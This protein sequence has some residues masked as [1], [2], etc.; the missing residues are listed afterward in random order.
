MSLHCLKSTSTS[1]GDVR[2]LNGRDYVV[3]PV[4]ALVEGVRHAGGSPHPELV[5]AEAFGRHV[6]TWNGRPI[7][8]DHPIDDNGVSVLA[9]SPG[10]LETCYL[11]TLLNAEVSDG[12]LKTEAWLDLSAIENSSSDKVVEMWERLV[13]GQTVEVSVGAIV[14]T[15]QKKGTYEGKKYSGVWDIVIP[16]HLAFLSGD[17]IGACSIDDGCG[18]YRTQSLGSLQLSEGIRMAVKG[19]RS[20][21]SLKKVRAAADEVETNCECGCGGSGRCAGADE[22]DTVEE[23]VGDPAEREVAPQ[24]LSDSVALA[25]AVHRVLF[26]MDT[27]DHDRRAL[28]SRALRKKFKDK[29]PYTIAYNDSMV[30][31]EVYEDDEYKLY[32]VA[33]TSGDDNSVSIDGEPEEVIVQSK[34][35]PVVDAGNKSM[36]GR[37]REDKSMAKVK[38]LETDED[39]AVVCASIDELMKKLDGTDVG[40]ALKAQ[41]SV[42]S[43]AKDKVVE[44]ILSS[45]GG[46]HFTKEVLSGMDFDVL[47]RMATAMEEAAAPPVKQ[48]TVAEMESPDELVEDDGAGETDLEDEEVV[49]EVLLSRKKKNSAG[50]AQRNYAGRPGASSSSARSANAVPAAPD[51]FDDFVKSGEAA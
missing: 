20:A 47:E 34:V 46:K 16:D 15:Q 30:L 24:R 26:S 50:T 41:L 42:A 32:Q 31:F 39:D 10:I 48:K 6:A 27:F 14:Y 22:E 19:K 28:L 51:I 5:L 21:A 18:T 4:V 13:D 9:S 12:K 23:V 40:R 35:V 45:K 25:G 2:T 11:G 17:Q 38:V 37:E 49:E 1:S 8:V 3:V 7:V 43:A 44:R 33:Y 36:S 29:Y